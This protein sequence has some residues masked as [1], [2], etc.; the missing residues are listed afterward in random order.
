MDWFL[1]DSNLRHERVNGL[2]IIAKKIL[3]APPSRGSFFTFTLEAKIKMMIK[4]VLLI[5]LT[6]IKWFVVI[7]FGR[8]YVMK[9]D[10]KSSF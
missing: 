10:G 8:V 4:M 6:I 7:S 5:M 9:C 1:S 2:A 3:N